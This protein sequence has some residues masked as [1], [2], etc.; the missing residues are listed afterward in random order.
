MKNITP[1][2]AA[3]TIA[4]M[5]I[6]PSIAFAQN[7]DENKEGRAMKPKKTSMSL[8][9][10]VCNSSATGTI[11][12]P[13][14]KQARADIDLAERLAKKDIDWT[15]DARVKNLNA[16][17]KYA[18][19][20]GDNDGKTMKLRGKSLMKRTLTDAEKA[21]FAAYQTS[22]EAATK[23]RNDAIK[24]AF[25]A[26]KVATVSATNA[27]KA[28]VDTALA[29][30]KAA[31]DAA[32]AT[33]KTNCN[34]TDAEKLAAEKVFKAAVNTARTEYKTTVKAATKTFLEATKPARDTRLAA[35]KTAKEAF[36]ASAKTARETLLAA[37]KAAKEAAAQ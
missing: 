32:T 10:R 31:I 35:V 25:E 15:H 18:K 30:R 4:S 1:L 13:M 36:Q 33:L 6:S 28:A 19:R 9:D 16:S 27:R 14:I 8:V 3:F 7:S 2:I 29:K 20:L 24:A 22:I 11:A 5:I 17:E 34:G 23:T 12:I 26:E 21:A 37:L